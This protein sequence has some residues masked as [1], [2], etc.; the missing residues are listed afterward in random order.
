M[1]ACVFLRAIGTATAFK[2]AGV[3]KQHGDQ[4][5][6]QIVKQTTLMIMG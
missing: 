1:C 6:A 2:G 5:L 4:I 3:E